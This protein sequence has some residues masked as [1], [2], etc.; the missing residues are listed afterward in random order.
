MTWALM[1]L[2][3]IASPLAIAAIDEWLCCRDRRHQ[4]RRNYESLLEKAHRELRREDFTRAPF[5]R[6]PGAAPRRHEA[7][8]PEKSRTTE[9]GYR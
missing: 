6:Y 9:G 7:T 2:G 5:A 8:T 3:I 4:D 1:F